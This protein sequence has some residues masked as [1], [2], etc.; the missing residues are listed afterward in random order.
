MITS[1]DRL[2]TVRRTETLKCGTYGTLN[3]DR[4][5]GTLV[6]RASEQLFRNYS[7]SDSVSANFTATS[8]T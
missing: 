1:S 2:L 7:R 8:V 4:Y 3:L 5:R 6:D